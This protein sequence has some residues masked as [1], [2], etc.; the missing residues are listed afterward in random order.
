MTHAKPSFPQSVLEWLRAGYPEGVPP[1]DRIPLV[2][3]LHRRLTPEEIKDVA[4]ALAEA[5]GQAEDP[6]ITRSRIGD[7]IEE[8][9]DT[10]PSAEDI[11]RV[12]AV[13]VSA[14]W[15]LDGPADPDS[16]P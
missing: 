8:V 15:S 3:L 12:E 10:D 14:G 11:A 5:A 16:G 7:L 6:T 9:T 2:A 4:V 1:K 13:L